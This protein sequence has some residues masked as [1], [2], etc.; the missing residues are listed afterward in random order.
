MAAV[1]GL[2]TENGALVRTSFG[3]EVAFPLTDHPGYDEISDYLVISRP[4]NVI[5]KGNY[6]ESAAKSLRAEGWNV[7]TV[8]EAAQLSLF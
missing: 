5:L 1:S 6:G 4:K 7:K 3:A 2:S 8:R